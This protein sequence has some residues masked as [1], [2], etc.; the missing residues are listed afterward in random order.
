MKRHLLPTFPHSELKLNFANI[1]NAARGVAKHTKIPD[2][3]QFYLISLRYIAI[4]CFPH[5]LL[6]KIMG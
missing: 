6:D 4:H 3:H 1:S 5:Q 2:V